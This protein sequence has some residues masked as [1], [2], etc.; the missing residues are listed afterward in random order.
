M[1]TNHA[2][3]TLGSRST[4]YLRH[5]IVFHAPARR[6][7]HLVI[8]GF[9]TWTLKGVWLIFTCRSDHD[10]TIT[11]VSLEDWCLLSKVQASSLLKWTGML[12]LVQCGRSSCVYTVAHDREWSAKWRQTASKRNHLTT[13]L[14][15]NYS[16][17]LSWKIL[18]RC[19][20][21]PYWKHAVLLSNYII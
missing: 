1:T 2:S 16:T 8:R 4:H 11:T 5:P 17:A 14:H 18:S 7:V 13:V 15:N 6:P 3:Y 9:P 20:C 12:V 10:V 21:R 19:T